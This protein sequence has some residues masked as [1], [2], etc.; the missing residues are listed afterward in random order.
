MQ[1]DRA[2]ATGPLVAPLQQRLEVGLQVAGETLPAHPA[3]VALGAC[4]QRCFGLVRLKQQTRFGPDRHTVLGF[5]RHLGGVDQVVA[6]GR[7]EDRLPMTRKTGLAQ[8]A[9]D[10]LTLELGQAVVTELR[11]AEP[12][13]AAETGHQAY[14]RRNPEQA[15][16][17]LVVAPKLRKFQMNFPR[18]RRADTI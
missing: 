3:D 2:S 12:F 5:G 13:Y 11:P 14:F 18:L 4:A 1:Q 6:A 7:D 15:Y 17:A 10:R 16:C 9:I 8:Q